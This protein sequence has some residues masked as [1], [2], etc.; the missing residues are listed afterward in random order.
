M[1]SAKY[2]EIQFV[3]GVA[4]VVSNEIR[5]IDNR[6]SGHD[7]RSIAATATADGNCSISSNSER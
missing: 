3:A 2:P 4:Q 6:I 5:G 1:A 7:G